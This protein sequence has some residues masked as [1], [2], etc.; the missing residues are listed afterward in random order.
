LLLSTERPSLS[1]RFWRIKEHSQSRY[2]PDIDGLRAVA[3]IAVVIYHFFPGWA[4][5]GFV[6]VDVFF[7]ISGFLISGIILDGLAKR[8]FSYTDFYIRRIKRI[9]P[10]LILVLIATLI[11]GW[12]VLFEDEFRQLG[13][14][15]VAGVLFASNIM[16]LR[17]GGY[18]DIAAELKPLLHLWSLA[19]EEQFYVLWPLLLIW[20]S[21]RNVA[22]R[23]ILLL[24]AVSFATNL[25]LTYTRPSYA[26]Y[27]SFP[28]FWE[29]M[30]GSA[31]ATVLH[32]RGIDR[33]PGMSTR[34]RNAIAILGF[35]LIAFAVFHIGAD[36]VFPGWWA[37]APTV[38]AFL[39]IGAGA[40]AWLN[41]VALSNEG[42]VSIGLLSYPLYLWHWV[43]LYF[44]RVVTNGEPGSVEKW[45]LIAASFIL[46]TLS[47][48]FIEF[49]IRTSARRVTPATVLSAI[50]IAIAAVGV[51]GYKRWI[52][53]RAPD[54][55]QEVA[56]ARYD[57]I[58][59]RSWDASH[60]LRPYY[61]GDSARAEMLFFGDSHMATYFTRVERVME[62]VGQREKGVAFSTASGCP[63][64]PGVDR[65]DSVVPEGCDEFFRQ[66][67]DY[68]KRMKFR[69]IVMS[70]Y[71]D[72]YFLG[73]HKK[74]SR[75][76]PVVYAIDDPGKTPIAPGTD[77]FR[78]VFQALEIEL[79]A[80]AR[81]GAT[82]Y[83]ILSN[84]SS[85]MFDPK[86]VQSQFDRLRFGP[87]PVPR[88]VTIDRR[89]F[90]SRV[91]AVN[92]AFR[93]LSRRIGVVL[94][95]PIP[96]LCGATSCASMKDG[97]LIYANDN[98]LTA[99]YVRSHAVYVDEVFERRLP[100]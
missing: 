16:L 72:G 32:S 40:D 44:G 25:W 57:R 17:E 79:A 28:R 67:I 12:F 76:G 23:F 5:G 37:L 73:L 92:D 93:E 35:A 95:D 3:V 74:G 43:A 30:L 66:T 48:Y 62:E 47:F 70:G 15:I 97:R 31:L 77:A 45:C 33:L 8:T 71:W 78:R 87:Q 65:V 27:L 69:K 9:F 75:K 80:L 29:L 83:V 39:V 68:A 36:A 10:P 99:H 41:R 63:P 55:W 96:S 58:L 91:A 42:M 100:R 2:R 50:M 61:L 7:V 34:W 18:F 84:P 4:T 1:Y 98:H 49:P 46:A 22:I 13:K 52:P 19:I 24:A 20:T 90:E 64:L 81:E 88:E 60:R 14:H 54:V 11:A 26:F 82:V 59:P 86:Q 38:G 21:R 94:I 6:G 51:T 89:A 53:M 85:A 56:R